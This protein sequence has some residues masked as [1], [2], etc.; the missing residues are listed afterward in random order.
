MEAGVGHMWGGGWKALGGQRQDD[1]LHFSS[2][3]S[4]RC[5]RRSVLS[6]PGCP[7]LV[8]GW[9]MQNSPRWGP[10]MPSTQAP[11]PPDLPRRQRTGRGE[12]PPTP[13]A[14]PRVGPSAAWSSR[15]HPGSLPACWSACCQEGQIRLA[16]ATATATPRPRPRPR[17]RGASQAPA[18]PAAPPGGDAHN[19]CWGCSTPAR[20]WVTVASH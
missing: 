19:Q 18:A 12:R 14:H 3:G 5:L 9:G 4:C 7:K 1:W 20:C 10:E 8:T 17:P 6:G 2:S 15:L 13:G 16:T 11:G